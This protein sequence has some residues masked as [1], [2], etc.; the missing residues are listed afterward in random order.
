MNLFPCRKTPIGAALILLIGLAM[1]LTGSALF[2]QDL[3]ASQVFDSVSSAIVVV[4]NLDGRGI[5][6][7][8]GSGVMLPSGRII[9]NFHVV[10]NG[11]KFLAGKNDSFYNANI[12][13]YDIS[14]DLCLLDVPGLKGSSVV[15][16]RSSNLK[17]GVPVYAVGSPS[18]L[19]FTLSSGL[20]SQLRGGTPPI[21]QTTAAISPGSSGGGLFDT[22]GRLVGITTFQVENGQNLNFALPAEWIYLL[23]PNSTSK[24]EDR[25]TSEWVAQ[26]SR[27]YG[28]K[29]WAELLELTKEWIKYDKL[30]PNAWYYMSLAYGSLYKWQEAV[31]ADK[32]AV[33][34]LPN[35]DDFLNNLG[36]DLLVLKEYNESMQVLEKAV[37]INSKNILA[38][39]N[40]GRCY[41]HLN[42]AQDAINCFKKILTLDSKNHD[43][44]R[45]LGEAYLQNNDL[46]LAKESV[47][48]GISLNP[49]DQILWNLLLQICNKM[50]SNSIEEFQIISDQYPLEQFAWSAL[51]GLYSLKDKN[52]ESIDCYKRAILISPKNSNFY[53]N[54]GSVYMKNNQLQEAVNSFNVAI[55]LAPKAIV[56]LKSL[57]DAYDKMGKFN[58]AIIV[59]RKVIQLSPKFKD[60]WFYLAISYLHAGNKP[61][62]TEAL[63]EVQKIDP[64]KAEE[65]KR[66]L[67]G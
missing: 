15:I 60:I 2:A 34:L 62:A 25:D 7:G 4:K 43:V 47:A 23:K 13:A 21:I 36:Y 20:V 37:S 12:Y 39:L 5:T 49:K 42:R 57:G 22:Q 33:R 51:A 48:R 44:W 38:L 30:D 11:S 58:D 45:D 53:W 54:L 67:G 8:Q 28:N 61:A 10:K 26:A 52:T 18:G 27:L 65:L 64:I 24:E 56:Y 9:T 66:L 32:E 19:E 17:I 55:D 6:K 59:Y 50:Q 29:G 1:A 63:L 41:K 35:N 31:N 46:L 40:L 14:K 16:G 3:S